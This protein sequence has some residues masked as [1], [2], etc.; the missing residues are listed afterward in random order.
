MH[1]NRAFV[2]TN[3]WIY[4]HSST[5]PDKKDT[6]LE[7]LNKYERVIST[8]VLSEFSNVCIRKMGLPTV[9]K[10]IEVHKRYRY[11][12]YDSLLIATALKNKCSYF[13]T[14][15][16]T[17]GQIVESSLVIKNIFI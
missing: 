9:F 3:L 17:D 13:L 2:D 16:M 15:D 5:E 7:T 14:E 4:L 8:Q 10:A 6:V 11:S 12:F 1:A